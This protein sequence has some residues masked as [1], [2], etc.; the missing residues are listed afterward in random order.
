MPGQS[1]DL[2]LTHAWRYHEDWTKAVALL[3]ALEG[4]SWRNFSVPW[5][6]P[7][8]DPNSE[9]GGRFIRDWLESQIIPVHAVLLLAGVHRLGSAR[10]WVDLELDYAARHEKL[11]LGLPAIGAE[12]DGFPAELRGRAA[13]VVP[14]DAA[15]IVAA[16][17]GLMAGRADAGALAKQAGDRA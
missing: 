16:L 8:M 3:D 2:F 12:V 13:A 9:V 17:E 6:D 10:K 5:H 4:L 1:F 14:W 7:A 11:V 15:R